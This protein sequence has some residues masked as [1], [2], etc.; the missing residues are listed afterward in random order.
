MAHLSIKLSQRKNSSIVRLIG[1]TPVKDINNFKAHN[2][3]DKRFDDG[4]SWAILQLA[5]F[6]RS[7][8]LKTK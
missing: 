4:V 1:I 3:W 2:Y 7:V 6:K 5:E 8:W